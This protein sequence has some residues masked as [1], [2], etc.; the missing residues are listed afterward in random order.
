MKN[1]LFILSLTVCA[2]VTHA[3]TWLANDHQWTYSIVSAFTQETTKYLQYIVKDTVVQGQNCK[4]V[5]LNGDPFFNP[6]FT[7]FKYAYAED[8]KVFV[9]RSGNGGTWIKIYD[10]NLQVGDTME[11]PNAFI[12]TK[13]KIT[14]VDEVNI[15]QQWVKRQQWA[16]LN[17]NNNGTNIYDILEGI[18]NVGILG[19]PTPQCSHFFM[20]ELPCTSFV[21]GPDY[22]FICFSSNNNN[23]TPYEGCTVSAAEPK[24]DLKNKVAVYPNPANDHLTVRTALNN[25]IRRVQLYDVQGAL[26]LEVQPAETATVDVDTAQLP[27]G[28]YMLLVHSAEGQYAQLVILEKT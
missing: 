1:I 4:Q 11:I 22:K 23:Y 13:Y 10:F 19:S 9:W 7:P 21:D 16:Q 24:T 27:A 17:N 28:M 3:Q 20:D 26:Q 25:P 12:P 15:G 5:Y 8:N 2:H 14:K 18:G 6:F